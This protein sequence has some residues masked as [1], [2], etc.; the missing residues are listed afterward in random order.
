MTSTAGRL[1]EGVKAPWG[2]AMLRGID[3]YEGNG[4]VDWPKVAAD[5]NAFAYVRGAYGDHADKLAHQNFV[6]ARSAGLPVGLYHFYRATRDASEQARTIVRTLKTVGFAEGDLLPAL[7]VEDN[8]HY[9]GAWDKANNDQYIAG[10]RH[11]IEQ[12][13]EAFGC[14]VVI[15]TRASFWAEIGNPGGFGSA[16]LWVAN[17]SVSSPKI[18]KGWNKYTLWQ[19]SDAGSTAGVHGHCDQNYFNGTAGDLAQIKAGS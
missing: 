7:D 19:Y 3:V 4:A 11:W 2:I 6:G 14:P 13:S 15:Y 16:R 10:L 1:V 12:V 17:Y 8:P 9:D 18:P 5:G